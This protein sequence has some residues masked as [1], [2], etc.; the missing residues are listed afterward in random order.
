MRRYLL[1]T[2]AAV[3]AMLVLTACSGT[4]EATTTNPEAA[5]VAAAPPQPVAALSAFYAMYKPARTWAADLLPLSLTAGEVPGIANEGGK[6]ALWT[7]V[8][9]SPSLRQA[10][11]LTWAAGD[12]GTEIHKGVSIGGAQVW[13]GATPQS[14]PFQNT[15]FAIDS[16]KAYKTAT[17]DAAAW[18]KKNPDKKLTVFTLVSAS[19]FPSPVWFFRWG[20]TKSGYAAFVNATTG[21]LL[22]GK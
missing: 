16:E 18:L 1:I 12:S 6:A 5:K 22:K 19:R 13:S 21:D 2:V 20:D 3:V 15:E 14:K 10:R 4:P 11:T 7:A 17:D 8:F 9:V